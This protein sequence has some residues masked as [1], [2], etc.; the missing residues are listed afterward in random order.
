MIGAVDKITREWIE[1][2]GIEVGGLGTG[3]RSRCI[4]G[5]WGR[6]FRGVI[7]GAIMSLVKGGGGEEDREAV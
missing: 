2:L 5:Q 7:S 4:E 3:R 6:G 1:C